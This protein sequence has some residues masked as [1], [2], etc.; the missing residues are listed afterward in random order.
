MK[1]DLFTSEAQMVALSS[2]REG[3]ALVGAVLAMLVVGAMVTGGFYA[4]NQQ[5]QVVRSA[6]IG[7]M[8]QYIAETG[9]EATMGRTTGRTLNRI[10]ANDVDTIFQN[11]PVSYGGRVVGTYTTTVLRTQGSLYLVRSTGTVTLGGA[12]T[13]GAGRTVA[14]V[15]R[16]RNVDFDNNTAMQVFGDLVVGGTADIEGSDTNLGST[17]SDDNCSTSSASAV[18]AQPGATVREQGSGD[19][20]GSIT[21]QNMDSTN[22]T[23]FGDMTWDEVKAL[24]SRSYAPGTN[25]SQI[26]PN[27]TPT[28]C[29]STSVCNTNVH[30]NWG[31]PESTT[32]PCRTHFPIIY[33]QGDLH[34][35]VNG[36]GQGIL[37]VEGDLILTSQF[38]FYG[39]VVI[40]GVLDVGAGGSQVYGSVL[41]FGGGVVGADNSVAGS[42][43]VQYSSCSISRAVLGATGLSRGMPI[44]HRSWFDV[45][46]VQSF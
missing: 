21:R 44:R 43:T 40:K 1:H 14:N 23:V 38:R 16:L 8:A 15:V 30:N 41:A 34:I 7:E 13:Q 2:R 27:C 25:L 36:S 46:N 45:T 35:S 5:S 26:Q 39:P 4:A 33:A 31:A 32:N 20:D 9:L 11:V 42:A 24:A 12:N 37:L 10:D 18:T 17:W 28:N 22:F 3:F 6:Y 29:N 19:I